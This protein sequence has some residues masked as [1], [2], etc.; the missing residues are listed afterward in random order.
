MELAP[1][2]AHQV[3][4]DAS[5]WGEYYRCQPKVMAGDINHGRDVL[6]QSSLLLNLLGPMPILFSHADHDGDKRCAQ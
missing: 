6:A 1:A 2:Q 3:G 5:A 4:E